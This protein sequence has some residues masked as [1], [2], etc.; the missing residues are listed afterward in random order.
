MLGEWADDPA[1]QRGMD[2]LAEL[3][4]AWA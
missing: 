2:Q 1:R 4:S 3:I